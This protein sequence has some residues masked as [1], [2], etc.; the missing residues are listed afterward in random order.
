MALRRASARG[1]GTVQWQLLRSYTA[2]SRAQ[3][4]QAPAPAAFARS[5]PLSI[6]GSGV[7]TTPAGGNSL[8]LDA[9]RFMSQQT[10]SCTRNRET[11]E[12]N[13]AKTAA[14]ATTATYEMLLQR[15]YQVNRF[16]AVKLGLENMHQ[17]NTAFGD[18]VSMFKV[19]HVAGTNGKG[20]VAFK[21]AKALERSG[22]KTGLF[23]SP[24]IAC[25]RER[26]QINGTLISE[27]EMCVILSEIFNISTQMRIPA[28][29]FEITTMLAFQHFFKQDVDCVVLETGLGGR[30]D[31]TNI[32]TPVLSVITSI[33]M[34]HVRILGNTLEAIAREKAGIIKP[35]VPVVVGP[36]TPVNV[37]MEYAARNNSRLVRVPL[38][39]DFEEDYNVENTAIA[40]EACVQLNALHDLQSRGGHSNLCVDLTDE[41]VNVALES[42]PPC[43]FQV[44]HVIRPNSKE[45][46]VTVVLDVAH[47][48]QAI[49]RLAGLLHK[50]FFDKKFRFVCGFSSDKAIAQVLEKI[51]AMVRGSH[52]DESDEQL[53]DRIHLVKANH[54]RGASLEEINLALASASAESGKKRKYATISNIKEGV[55]AAL[56]AS[57]ASVDD[58]VVVVCGS[59]FLMAEARQALGLKE[60]TDS[61]SIAA[62]VSSV[63][64]V[65]FQ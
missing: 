9:T 25:F 30:L 58:E 53:Q 3:L 13:T 4:L 65:E 60:P 33:G 62:M 49:D 64:P 40:R 19:I 47:N 59:L 6:S 44:L 21:V 32:V 16:T 7:L 48:P 2:L 52:S 17:L 45:R 35:N 11:G 31:S 28:T 5:E 29:F 8:L 12:G 54:P 22:Y 10:V 50:K 42:R 34:D 15:L 18:P 27:S 1:S 57:R 39:V 41:R 24:H 51:T 37:M 20:S 14:A 26:I 61:I 38:G 36:N 55:D 43:R 63:P 56:A 46:K 23:V